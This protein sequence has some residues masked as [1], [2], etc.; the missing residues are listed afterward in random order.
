MKSKILKKNVLRFDHGDP[1]D[2]QSA[3]R[4]CKHWTD[5]DAAIHE[6]LD[7]YEDWSLL[8]T[9]KRLNYLL[10]LTVKYFT[11]EIWLNAVWFENK[12]YEIIRVIDK[13][14]SIKEYIDDGDA[15]EIAPEE[16]EKL[17]EQIQLA[18]ELPVNYMIG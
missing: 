18:F 17:E 1:D 14:R 3:L 5:H 11:H 12:W 6:F 16:L 10:S 13:P 8:L 9:V 4:T 2:F 7:V 15:V